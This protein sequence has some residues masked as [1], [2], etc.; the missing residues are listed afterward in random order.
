[1]EDHGA[2]GRPPER[3]GNTIERGVK[4]YQKG[5]IPT[6]PDVPN[7][8]K[9]RQSHHWFRAV[10]GARA[11]HCL[12]GGGRSTGAPPKQNGAVGGGRKG[13]L[14]VCVWVAAALGPARSCDVTRLLV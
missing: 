13:G 1:M 2:M 7:V 6:T 3:G 14:G 10:Y 8:P 5:H 9:Q 12:G 11:Q 4:R